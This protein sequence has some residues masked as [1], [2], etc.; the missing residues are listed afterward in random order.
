LTLL[1]RKRQREALVAENMENESGS[2]PAKL[3]KSSSGNRHVLETS[4]DKNNRTTQTV[5]NVSYYLQGSDGERLL[6]E[7]SDFHT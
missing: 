3:A 5:R 4:I 2:R 7:I 1:T 6:R